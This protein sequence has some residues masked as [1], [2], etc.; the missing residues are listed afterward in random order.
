MK[1]SL[2]NLSRCEKNLSENNQEF[3]PYFVKSLRN[4]SEIIFTQESLGKNFQ[5][6]HEVIA[7]LLPVDGLTLLLYTDSFPSS[8]G[9]YHFPKEVSKDMAY[10]RTQMIEHMLEINKPVTSIIQ[11]SDVTSKSQHVVPSKEH[12]SYIGVPLQHQSKVLGVLIA[13]HHNGH[14]CYQAHHEQL[15]IFI[16]QLLSLSLSSLKQQQEMQTAQAQ[17]KA[18]NEELEKRVEERTQHIKAANSVLEQQILE[19]IKIEE[20]LKHDAFHDALTSLPNRALFIDRLE[21]T[22]KAYQRQGSAE[23]AV[24]YLDLDRF[25]LVNDSLGH[26]IGDLL[27]IEVAHRLLDCVRPSDTVARIGGDEFCILLNEINSLQNMQDIANRVLAAFQVPFEIKAN[28]IVSSTSIGIRT[29]YEG[30]S[31]SE[32][33]LRDAD[34][35]LYH[36]K[37]KGR[38][39]FA[40]FDDTMLQ[41]VTR[42]ILIEELLHEAVKN[43]EI[44]V[45][46]QPVIDMKSR[47]ILLFETLARWHT[48]EH[49]VIAPNEFIPIAEETGLIERLEQCILRKALKNLC[50]WRKQFPQLNHIG[51]SLNISSQQF[52]QN[53]FVDDILMTLKKYQLPSSCLYL[54]I[55]EALL[56]NHFDAACTALKQL[57]ENSVHIMLDNFGT[58]FSSLSYLHHFPISIIKIDRSF[59]N[60]L[61]EQDKNFSLVRSIKTLAT[62]LQVKVVAEGIETS[63]QA[64]KVQDLNCEY[65]Q[66]F[67]YSRP[68]H[69]EDMEDYLKNCERWHP[70][71]N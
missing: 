48:N 60:H 2:E 47:R 65:A 21:H 30:A 29:S 50:L 33:I 23:F 15:L 34:T 22:I 4:I 1:K 9:E 8:E 51:V 16:A 49:G 18:A 38:N 10:L 57:H 64:D 45:Y 40:A 54:E 24:F 11:S 19:R 12:T 71:L 55:T 56:I 32:E 31:S 62:D 5:K 43:D 28:S 25:K 42:R 36:A 59:V 14:F 63:E 17:L 26:I 52:M 37:E 58:G 41:Q 67:L 13:Y 44:Y 7:T 46:F 53:T 69:E 27:L 70:E 61:E 66:G 20:K 68:I 3:C 39:N 35:A 6:I